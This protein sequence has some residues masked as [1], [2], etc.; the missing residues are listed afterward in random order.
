M[1]IYKL[2]SPYKSAYEGDY[3]R[4]LFVC[5][6][7]QLRSPTAAF[8][9]QRD[10]AYNTRSAGVER[11]SLIPLTTNLIYWADEIVYM[12]QAV[13]DKAQQQFRDEG[14]ETYFNSRPYKIWQIPDSYE[15][16]NYELID[17]IKKQ[18]KG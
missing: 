13:Y 9:A 16:M 4:W 6:S 1:T 10:L 2:T 11:Y 5:S 3:P 17:L 7:G 8:V 12:D 18:L 14:L 15:F